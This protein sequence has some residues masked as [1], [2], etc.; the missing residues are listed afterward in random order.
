LLKSTKVRHDN[1]VLDIIIAHMTSADAQICT[2]TN[3]HRKHK[4][5]SGP[6]GQMV[7]ISVTNGSYV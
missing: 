5:I 4:V 1:N 3:R 6:A 7:K 2:D